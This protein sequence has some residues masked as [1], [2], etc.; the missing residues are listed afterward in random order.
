MGN[1]EFYMYREWFVTIQFLE[2]KMQ[3]SVLADILK[4]LDEY[5]KRNCQENCCELLSC[6]TWA[7]DKFKTY[8]D[9]KKGIELHSK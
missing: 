7:L 1:V 3:L 9:T 8:K 5:F 4:K 2:Q 6:A